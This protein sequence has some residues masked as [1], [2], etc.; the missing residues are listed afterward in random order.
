M[1]ARL[2]Y[3]ATRKA[4]LRALERKRG[5]QASLDSSQTQLHAAREQGALALAQL[6][7]ARRDVA[8]HMAAEAE[9]VGINERLVEELAKGEETLAAERRAHLDELREKDEMLAAEQAMGVKLAET[10]R[11][12]RAEA[13]RMLGKGQEAEAARAGAERDALSHELAQEAG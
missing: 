11:E 9:V 2:Q 10:L 7:A 12:A 5:L 8:A 3:A 4:L 1:A 6:D 13:V